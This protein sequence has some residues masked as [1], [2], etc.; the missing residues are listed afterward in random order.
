M[1]AGVLRAEPTLV[2]RTERLLKAY[3][4]KGFAHVEYIYSG[5]D[6]EFYLTEVNPRLPGY[7]YLLSAAG[8]EQGWYYVADLTGDQYESQ[9]KESGVVYFESLRYP[10]DLTDG[11]VNG[12]RGNLK[13]SALL[14]SYWRAL[15]SRDQVVV[16]HFNSRDPGLTFGLLLFNIRSF[17][18][19]AV[20]YIRRRVLRN[21]LA[22]KA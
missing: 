20:S 7:A 2:E 22:R 16:D 9:G 13:F 10:G 12:L 14:E 3:E 21:G 1:Y 11:V 4:W 6:D 18:D 17:V 15:I 8:H 19:K 5:I